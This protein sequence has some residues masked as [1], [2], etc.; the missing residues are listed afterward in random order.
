MNRPGAQ[1][2]RQPVRQPAGGSEPAAASAAR[3]G[4]RSARPE[5]IIAAILVAVLSG[6]GFA[7]A[8]PGGTALVLIITAAVALV[9]LR[10]L[11]QPDQAAPPPDGA[12][13]PTGALGSFIGF[14]RKRAELADGTASMSAYDV[15]L[16]VTLQRLLAARLSERHGISL[17]Q[18]PESARRLLC[19]GRPDDGLWFWVDP[20]RPPGQDDGSRSG[21]PPRT[22]ATL[23]DRLERL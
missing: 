13:R 11:V 14:I 3:T 20:A 19:P 23:I 9:A 5:L 15:G 12:A 2:A 16:R 6:A 21:I 22:L 8:G 7:F 1:A 4:W 10:A 17:Y 18:D